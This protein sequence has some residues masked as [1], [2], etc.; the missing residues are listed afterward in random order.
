MKF[1]ELMQQEQITIDFHGTLQHFLGLKVQCTKSTIKE[2]TIHVSQ[3]SFIDNLTQEM[4]LNG[5]NVNI[6]TTPYRSDYVIDTIK[7]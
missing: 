6:P 2:V 7:Q 4:S 1:K 5:P 3:Q